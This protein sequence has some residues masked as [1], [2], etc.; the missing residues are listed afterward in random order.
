MVLLLGVCMWG[1]V[2]PIGVHRKVQ[3]EGVTVPIPFG[4]VEQTA[5]SQAR[6]KNSLYPYS[7]AVVNLRRASIPFRPWISVS[8]APEMPG[9]P[10]TV[11]SARRQQAGMYRDSAYYS[12][13]RTFD[14]SSGKYHSV[15]A[16]ATMR[17]GY[18]ILTCAVVGTPLSL[19]FMGSKAVD[20]EAEKMLTSLT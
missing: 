7:I 14:L 4:W 3:M 5:G 12:N 18:Q 9:G 13:Q 15:C 1:Y 8:I 20:A 19:D 2:N 10:Y 17:T 6:P 16:E 11:D